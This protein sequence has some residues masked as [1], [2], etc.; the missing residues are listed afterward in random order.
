M[1]MTKTYQKTRQ[2]AEKE[3]ENLPG[4]PGY[5]REEDIYSNAKEE[6]EIDPENTDSKKNMRYD[7]SYPDDLD[8]PGAELDDEQEDLGNEDEENNY[9]SFPD[10][11]NET[12]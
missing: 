4:Y 11:D 7:E 2:K 6:D 1:K 9:Y 8:I 12:Y 3:S 5:S 10:D